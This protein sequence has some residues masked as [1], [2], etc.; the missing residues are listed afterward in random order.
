ME[1]RALIFDIKRGSS[2]DGPGIRTTVF[3]KGCPLSCVWCQ[4]PEGIELKPETDLNGEPIGE[5]VELD[6][7]LYRVRHDK[8]FYQSSGGGITLSGGEPTRQ[9]DFNHHFLSALK[10]EG[11]HTAIETCGLFNYERFQQ[12]L[13]PWLDLIY[14]DLKLIDDFQSHRYT[15]CSNRSIL[16]NFL[17]L[18]ANSKVPI[19]PRI[20]LIPG[21]T[22][23]GYNLRGLADYLRKSGID[24][25][26]L[27]PYNPLWQDKLKRMGK[28]SSYTR[29][30]F[31][32]AEE[33]EASLRYFRLQQ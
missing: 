7:L 25:C 17:R 26:S 31:L 5:W 18:A 27:M 23:T 8:P 19:I 13:L 33:Q 32:S 30:T 12:Q 20:P 10:A 16:V 28:S 6:E 22:D 3:F 15:G 29:D 1:D 11:I 24:S 4:N 9:M 14:F 21:V 2:E